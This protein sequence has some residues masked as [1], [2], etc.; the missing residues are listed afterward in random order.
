[1]PATVLVVDDD[2]DLTRLMAKFLKLE[3]FG[4]AEACNGQEALTYASRWRRRE[5][6]PARPPHAGDGWV[7]VPPRAAGRSGAGR[8]PVVSS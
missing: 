7:G 1:M 8:I 6:H 2:R 3:G 5:R 4:A